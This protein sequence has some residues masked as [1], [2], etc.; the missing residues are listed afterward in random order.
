MKNV[1]QI[2]KLTSIHQKSAD[3]S[4]EQIENYMKE[5]DDQFKHLKS[6][7]CKKDEE[8]KALREEKAETMQKIQKL[9]S[10]LKVSTVFFLLYLLFLFVL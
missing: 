10:D 2:E 3:D 8:L 1:T 4:M 5:S 9:E 6:L 7:L